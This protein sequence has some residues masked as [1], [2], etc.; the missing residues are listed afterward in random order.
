MRKL[1]VTSIVKDVENI[2]FVIVE[3]VKKCLDSINKS[4]TFNKNSVQKH[5]F[6]YFRDK[7]V[8]PYTCTKLIASMIF[9]CKRI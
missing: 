6:A 9:N 7:F 3:F 4:K 2:C 1:P 8:F 5:S